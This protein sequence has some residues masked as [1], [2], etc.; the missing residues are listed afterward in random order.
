MPNIY[1]TPSHMRRTHELAHQNKYYS[2]VRK[3]AMW[4]ITNT[5]THNRNRLRMHTSTHITPSLFC[6]PLFGFNFL[7]DRPTSAE[8]VGRQ[9]MII[10][11]ADHRVV[12]LRLRVPLW[13]GHEQLN[14]RP[15]VE[16]R[17]AR[18]CPP[19]SLVH[20]VSID[21]MYRICC[22]AA[23]MYCMWL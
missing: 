15:Q 18:L 23:R 1:N 22:Y 11:D 13:N 8:Q 10:C 12:P 3:R 6:R 20:C 2:A 5:H 14:A 19:I 4:C 21:S 16:A 17:A 9:E 7:T